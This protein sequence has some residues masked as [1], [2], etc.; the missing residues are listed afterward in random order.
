MIEE[1][2]REKKRT[3]TICYSLQTGETIVIINIFWLLSGSP[4]MHHGFVF[5][6]CKANHIWSDFKIC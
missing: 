1:T 5:K 2:C 4:I 6:H 3:N